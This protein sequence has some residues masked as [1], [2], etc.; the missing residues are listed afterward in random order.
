MSGLLP[1]RFPRPFAEPVEQL[2]A[3]PAT[4]CAEQ[5]RPW[6]ATFCAEEAEWKWAQINRG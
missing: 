1:T 2:R 4:F 6:P 5:F 3:R